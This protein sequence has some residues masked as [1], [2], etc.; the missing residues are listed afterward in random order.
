M[1]GGRCNEAWPLE[2]KGL[3]LHTNLPDK[4]DF[5]MYMVSTLPTDLWNSPSSL[6]SHDRENED[7]PRSFRPSK[8]LR[9]IRD[10][11]A[12]G[13]NLSPKHWLHR[14]STPGHSRWNCPTASDHLAFFIVKLRFIVQI[15]S[16]FI[17]LN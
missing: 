8:T 4:P 7:S 13:R 15:L 14:R 2:L 17:Q 5:K 9:T 16:L 10:P 11:R 1:E 6:R 3:G 12:P